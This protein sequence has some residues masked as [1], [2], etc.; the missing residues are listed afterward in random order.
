MVF[1]IQNLYKRIGVRILFTS[2]NAEAI[3]T[4]T[5]FLSLFFVNGYQQQHLSQ[6][7]LG[8]VV[9]DLL[10]LHSEGLQLQSAHF[11]SNMKSCL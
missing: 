6:V 10:N 11:I 1:F 9:G 4:L 3:G 7:Q 2:R 5:I 8:Q